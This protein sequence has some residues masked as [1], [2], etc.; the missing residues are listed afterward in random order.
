MRQRQRRLESRQKSVN[1]RPFIT[2]TFEFYPEGKIMDLVTP[3]RF[4][5]PYVSQGK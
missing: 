2:E 1:G 4:D 5:G 3:F